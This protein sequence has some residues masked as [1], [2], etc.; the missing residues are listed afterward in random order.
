MSESVR[1]VS[2]DLI[3]ELVLSRDV[4]HSVSRSL[5]LITYIT[6][7]P[8]PRGH[9]QRKTGWKMLPI[10]IS[11]LLGVYMYRLDTSFGEDIIRSMSR[12]CF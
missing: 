9:K 5:R 12:C 6:P 1:K 2:S 3:A 11:G 4:P 10:P 7:K 8:Q